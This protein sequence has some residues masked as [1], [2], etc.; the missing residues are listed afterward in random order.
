MSRVFTIRKLR[1]S[2]N[3]EKR[4]ARLMG[5]RRVAGS[6]NQPGNKGDVVDDEWLTEA[7]QTV[8]PRYSLALLTWRKIE[9][10]AIAK[11]RRPVLIVEMAGRTLAV[12]DMDDFLTLRAAQSRIDL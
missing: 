9:R 2:V 3:Q 12:I 5:G 8:K 7:K 4:V 10:E 11:G 1:S 6:G